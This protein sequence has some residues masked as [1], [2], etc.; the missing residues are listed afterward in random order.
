MCILHLVKY[1]THTLLHAAVLGTLLKKD[2]QYMQVN[3]HTV[4][5]PD[6]AQPGNQTIRQFIIPTS[7]RCCKRL[8][9]G[10][11]YLFTGRVFG[12]FMFTN[13]CRDIFYYRYDNQDQLLY[14]HSN[15]TLA[16]YRP[17]C[18]HKL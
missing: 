7:M 12:R 5:F 18:Q 1:A 9:I 15:A 6:S 2:F 4:L 16:E 10:E 8:M 13:G 11:T 14:S 17:F 3:I